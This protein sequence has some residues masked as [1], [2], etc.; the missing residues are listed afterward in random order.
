MKKVLFLSVILLAWLIGFNDARAA[1][2]EVDF[3]TSMGIE[4]RGRYNLML[5]DGETSK[6]TLDLFRDLY[7]TNLPSKTPAA[8]QPKIPK[9]IHHIWIGPRPFPEKYKAYLEDCKRLHPGWKFILWTNKDIE[10]ILA[11]DPS[12]KWL[13]NEYKT[14]YAAQKDILEYLILYKHGGVYFDADVK[15]VKNMDELVHKYKFFSSIEPGSRWSRIPVLSARVVGS[16]PG[17]KIMS[18]ALKIAAS[19]YRKTYEEKN[20]S[21]MKQMI[22]K[23]AKGKYIKI[24]NSCRALM[25]ALGKAVVANGLQPETIVFPATYFDPIFPKLR[26]YDLMDEVKFRL[27]IY[28]NKNKPFHSIK[29]ETI[30]ISTDFVTSE[31]KLVL[32][33]CQVKD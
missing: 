1:I 19:S 16:S 33:A 2:L 6:K 18:D 15:C 24:P 31:D 9:I 26:R 30:G 22:R 21:L 32:E 13:F 8:E 28:G 25:G 7:N 17:N 12:Y 14:V 10:Q 3:D 4:E 27:G 23:V 11:I 20:N 29:P 5:R